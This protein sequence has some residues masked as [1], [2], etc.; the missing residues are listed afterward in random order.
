MRKLTMTFA[1]AVFVLGT[2]AVAANAQTQSPGAS[3]LHSQIQ[4]ATPIVKQAACRGWG[5]RCGPG[6]VWACGP[7]GCHCRPCY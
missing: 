7:Y 4:N 3:G 6:W 1:A 2:M 5:A